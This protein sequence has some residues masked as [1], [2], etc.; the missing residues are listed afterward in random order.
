MSRVSILITH[1]NTPIDLLIAIGSVSNQSYK[2]ISIHVVDDCS[3]S[4][5]SLSIIASIPWGSRVRFY[6]TSENV[7]PYRIKNRMMKLLDSEYYAFQDADDFS[8]PRRIERQLAHIERGYGIVGSSFF[9][10][11]DQA[12]TKQV[13]SMPTDPKQSFTSG[14]RFI[15]LHPTWLMRREILEKLKGF[16]G[17]TKIAADDEFIYRAMH[18]CRLAN[19]PEVLYVKQ[20]HGLSLTRSRETGFG[21]DLRDRYIKY[22]KEMVGRLSVAEDH[23][24][25]NLLMARENDINFSINE[26]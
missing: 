2:D 3:V 22:I 23:E 4:E 20:E 18:V 14:N 15:S 17:T 12:G 13:V 21:S 26:L 25:Q 10:I 6:R 19:V 24:K 11:D 7:G 8:L 5:K 16:D 9:Q 1:F